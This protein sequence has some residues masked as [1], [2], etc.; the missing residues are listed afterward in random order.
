MSRCVSSGNEDF[1]SDYNSRTANVLKDNPYAIIVNASNRQGENAG[2]NM[3]QSITDVFAPGDRVLS[4]TSASAEGP[5]A[6]SYMAEGDASPVVSD[7]FDN[8]SAKVQLYKNCDDALN[9]TEEIPRQ[10]DS[11][12]YYEGGASQKI[13]RDQLSSFPNEVI[14]DGKTTYHWGCYLKIPVTELSN[15][16]HLDFKRFL[17]STGDA[18]LMNVHSIAV[19]SEDGTISWAVGKKTEMNISD[20]LITSQNWKSE[21]MD[22][23]ATLHS[24]QTLALDSSGN[25]IVRVDLASMN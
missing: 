23:S 12:Y 21:T 13:T 16:A 8:G 9:L 14:E 6:A 1:D 18:F 15:L 10:P 22:M 17:E 5:G 24:G 7:H 20:M 4:T 3:G 25:I 11:Q 2:N 19:K